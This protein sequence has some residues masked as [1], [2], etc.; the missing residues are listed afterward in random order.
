MRKKKGLLIIMDGLG[1]RP[2]ASLGGKTPLEAAH[3]PNLDALVIQGMCGNVYPIAPG[4]R[5][6]TDVGHMQIFG[7]D[8]RTCYRG[9]GPLE[10]VSGGIVLQDGDVAFRGNFATVDSKLCV[11]DRRA[12]RISSGTDELAKALDGMQLSEDIIVLAKELTEHRIAIVLRGK[13][14]SD[15]ITCTDPG[16]GEEGMPLATPSPMNDSPEAAR[17]ARALAEFTAKAVQLLSEHPLN[18]ERTAQGKPCANVVITRGAGQKTEMPSIQK[19]YGIKAACIAGDVTVGGIATLTGMDYYT[20]SSFTGGFETDLQGKAE[21]ALRLFED[22]YAWVVLHVKGTDLA[23]HD[24][25]P[26]K[27]IEIIEAVDGMVGFLLTRLNLNDCYLSLTADHS[28]PCEAGD[29]TGDGVPTLIAGGDVR[30][31][32][33]GSVGETP[34]MMGALQNLTANDIFMLQMDLMGYTEKVGS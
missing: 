28:T 1:D 14:L 33:V 18:K 8:S 5:V 32:G 12:G 26:R 29:H 34:F 20:A 9:R 4:I 27:K 21:L 25:L 22:G 17:T 13:G 19:K 3:T 7:C 31:D 23:G 6:G 10:A 15:A 2:I 16:T 11:T 30:R 24:N